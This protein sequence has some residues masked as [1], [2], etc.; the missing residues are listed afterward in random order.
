MGQNPENGTDEFLSLWDI[1]HLGKNLFT[2]LTNRTKIRRILFVMHKNSFCWYCLDRRSELVNLASS[3]AR[4]SKFLAFPA[5]TLQNTHYKGFIYQG[6]EISKI[7]IRIRIQHFLKSQS[8]SKVQ[9][10]HNSQQSGPT[11][12]LSIYFGVRKKSDNH[13]ICW[14]FFLFLVGGGGNFWK[15]KF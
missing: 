2:K 11:T 5:P 9:T 8:G 4:R 7:T 10:N 12:Q 3:L 1:I 15:Q 13:I 14:K 6:P